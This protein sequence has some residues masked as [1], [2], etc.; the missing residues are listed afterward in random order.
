MLFS[1]IQLH[2]FL[3]LKGTNTLKFPDPESTDHALMLVL[4]ANTAGKTSIIRALKF[5]FCDDLLNCSPGNLSPLINDAAAANAS[6]GDT[7]NGWVQ[8]KVYSPRGLRTI[9][10]RIETSCIKPGSLRYVGKF[11]EEQTHERDGDKFH[12]DQGEIQRA[13]NLMVPPELFDYF[14]FEGE[15]LAERLVNGNNAQGI[16]DGLATLIQDHKW[17]E[18]VDG[19]RKIEQKIGKELEKFVGKHKEYQELVTKLEST[20][21]QI[22]SKINE[23]N[24]YENK[25]TEAERGYSKCEDDIQDL[26]KGK[27]FDKLNNDLAAARIKEKNAK[28]QIDDC[29]KS[30]GRLIGSSQGLPFYSSGFVDVLQQLEEMRSENILP[31]DVSEGFVNRILDWPQTKTCICGRSLD[32]K[33][34]S[35]QR[36]CIEDYRER[37]MA[38]DLSYA[39][40]SLLNSLESNATRG[41]FQA[42]SIKTVVELENTLSKRD[43]SI[44]EEKDSKDIVAG[45]E[46]ERQKSNI[47]EIQR[48]QKQQRDANS[49]RLNCSNSLNEINGYLKRL[50]QEQG[51]LDSEI[52]GLQHK[53]E[54]AAQIIKLMNS[55]KKARELADFIEEARVSVK[56]TF[57]SKLQDLV[58]Q[59]Y[60]PVVP[61]GSKAHVDKNSLLPAILVDGQVRRNISGGQRQLLVLSYIIS[62][63]QLRKWLHEEIERIGITPGRIDDHCF[64][65]DSVFGPT[66]DKFREKCAELLVGKAHQIIVSVASQQWDEKTQPPL[67]KAANKVYRFI[68]CT[69]KDDIK[70]EERTMKFRGKD[71]EVFRRISPEE[72]PYTLAEEVTL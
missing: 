44:L 63:S 39:L 34:H 66:A 17:G 45:F 38:G 31:A 35:D 26:S 64:G 60:D 65:L 5:L 53:G 21:T 18:A 12:S 20:K 46:D 23:K 49:T 14:F 24:A 61:D 27:S 71:I 16:K 58:S 51:K 33:T 15:S 36:K 1:E 8:V 72:K 67:E 57:H 43:E 11:L 70:P 4:A 59:Y 37:T 29:D 13:L 30:I 6:Q 68:L 55:Q 3:T 56:S 22:A 42:R 48:L 10:R 25:K 62:L 41:G 54:V 2:N 40:L 28:K 19:V 47:E 50:E 7:V 52:R 9:R 69:G 32:P